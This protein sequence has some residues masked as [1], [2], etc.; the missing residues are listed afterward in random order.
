MQTIAI[1][2]TDTMADWEY[3]HITA[4]VTRANTMRPGMFRILFVGDGTAEVKS[5]GGMHVKPDADLDDLDP[6]KIACLV[7]PGADTYFDGHD[8]LLA[9]VDRLIASCT[10]V[11]AICGAT[12]ALAQHG[13]LDDRRHT[14]NAALFL[15]HSGYAGG[16]HYVDAPVVTDRG[17][18][19]GSGVHSVAFAAEVF[20][21]S[22]LFG[23]ELADA[24]REL[25][26]GGGLAEYENFT[27]ATEK[28]MHA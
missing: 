24:W 28:V 16:E 8:R 11:A 15:Q 6:E 21:I 2:T 13:V 18:T 5:L 4:E 3:A 26:L 23:D 22:G 7:I 12:F 27:A 1:Y 9:T 20:R 10:P 19:T 14:S 25:Y 17:V